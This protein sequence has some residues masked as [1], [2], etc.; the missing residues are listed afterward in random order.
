MKKGKILMWILIS[1]TFLSFLFSLNFIS[2]WNFETDD[3]SVTIT[4][5]GGDTKWDIITS[6]FM[7]NNTGILDVNGTA[8]NNSIDARNV[9]AFYNATS[10]VTVF[11]TNDGGDINSLKIIKDGNSYN[12]SEAAGAN[13]LTIVVNFTNVN[14][15][16]VLRMREQY[17]GEVG[18][19]LAV[20]IYHCTDNSYEE[21]FG[22]ITDMANF[23]TIDAVIPDPSNHVCN[24]NVSIR[25]RHIQAG[26]PAHD[27]FLEYMVLIEGNPAGSNIQHDGLTGRNEITNHPWALPINGSL[28]NATNIIVTENVTASFYLGDGS[29]LVNL[30]STGNSTNE[31]F[32]AI[33]NGTFERTGHGYYNSSLINSTQMEEQTG[34]LLG[35][36]W[37]W[38]TTFWNAIFGT[39]TTDDLT[40][41]STNLYENST[42]NETRAN[43]L[44][45]EEGTNLNMS[46]FN[47]TLNGGW[48]C[49]NSTC[50]NYIRNNGT[51]WLIQG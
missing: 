12:V 35:I 20:G 38:L 18:H 9:I 22:D 27:F 15:F 46:G 47:I 7:V 37:S 31:I 3:I 2:A 13:P 51:G 19:E 43:S 29:Q 5:V 1:F 50:G 16:N 28:R 45:I 11:G 10:V 49:S 26:I 36:K 24:N 39:K 44:Y 33:T 41:G 17:L 42:W 48:I 34:G 30:P 25:I 21:E 14:T 23:A 32:G 40:E 4:S 6:E 8:L